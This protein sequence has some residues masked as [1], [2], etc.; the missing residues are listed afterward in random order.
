MKID[1]K[2]ELI[3]EHLIDKQ[4]E[5]AGHSVKFADILGKKDWFNQYL[6]TCDQADEF[7][8]YAYTYIKK[9]L[10]LNKD[11]AESELG[12]FGLQYGLR[13]SDP[14]NFGVKKSK[15]TNGSSISTSSRQ[16]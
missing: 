11:R 7:R 4:F 5:F 6:I 13:L 1:K 9:K 16:S 3:V 14:E 12:W 10:R 15:G 2:I 8:K